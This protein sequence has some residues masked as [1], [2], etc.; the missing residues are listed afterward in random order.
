M[1]LSDTEVEKQIK[2]MKKFIEQEAREKAEEI[3]IKAEEEFNIEKGR[4]LQNEKRKVSNYYE[5]KEKQL[6][7]QRKIQHSNML[8]QARLRVLKSRDDNISD[9]LEEAKGRLGEV[10]K[11]AARWR[12]M[13][14]D[15][16]TQGIYQLLE[17]EV[18]VRCRQVDI[19]PIK[20]VI[21]TVMAN[22]TKG[23]G[24]TCKIIVNES[25]P[26]P[27]EVAGVEV[28]AHDGKIKV[29]NTLDSRLEQLARQMMPEI[30][31]TL[32]GANPSRHFMD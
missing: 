27:S 22:Y 4:L 5:R 2:H 8:N 9:I 30:R 18:T 1:A 21:P 31:T 23:T 25:N 6:E 3:M 24:K 11:D 15:L 28:L 26:L 13:L 19:N 10:T 16:I 20:E 32:F 17:P 12:N 29:V 14:G 7:V